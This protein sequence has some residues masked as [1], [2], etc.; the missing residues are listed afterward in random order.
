MKYNKYVFAASL[1][2]LSSSVYAEGARVAQAKMID[3]MGNKVGIMTLVENGPGGVQISLN[4]HSLTPGLHGMHIH[5]IGHCAT[6]TFASAGPHFNPGG[7]DTQHGLLGPHAGD[8]PNLEVKPNGNAATT[9][10]NALVTLEPGM[11]NSLLDADGSAII[12]HQNPDD[13]VT[14]PTG[15]SG[16][17]VACGVIES[18]GN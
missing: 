2:M 15:S 6:P 16:P 8:L 5:A 9:I 14:Q 4:A 12:I 13:N 10:E 1:L 17:R 7:T 18:L 11:M 3:A